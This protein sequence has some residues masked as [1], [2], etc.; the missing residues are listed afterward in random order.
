MAR[1]PASA[2]ALPLLAALPIA[3]AAWAA[4]ADAHEAPKAQEQSQEAIGPLVVGSPAPPLSVDAWGQLPEGVDGYNWES[5][6]G[7]TVVLEFWATW[8]GPCIAAI[9]HMNELAEAFEGEVVFISVTDEPEEKTLA[10]R[11][12]RPMRSVLGFDPDR[13]MLKSYQVRGI[14]ATFVV[15]TGGTIAS[16]THPSRLTKEKLRG[17]IN[18]ERDTPAAETVPIDGANDAAEPASRR[19]TSVASGVDPLDR[20]STVPMGQFILREAAGENMLRTGRGPT[21]VTSLDSSPLE[22]IAYVFEVQ[23]WQVV[24]PEGFKDQGHWD[25][26]VRLPEETFGDQRALVRRLVLDGLGLE[27]T[28]QDRTV[29]GYELRVADGGLRLQEAD[30][31]EPGGFRTSGYTFSS[32]SSDLHSFGHWVQGVLGTPLDTDLDAEARYE[33]DFSMHAAFDPTDA[34]DL[35]MLRQKLEEDL[36]LVLEAKENVVPMVT[37]RPK[38]A[39]E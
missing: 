16:I 37:V 26:I 33:I 13:S 3:Q 36:G 7:R 4:P 23:T 11:E 18:G 38:L 8:C 9:P 15:D 32:A 30:P 19:V 22:L 5:L 25:L 21:N 24:T 2:R 35:A 31:V 10:L 39:S 1:I 14:P 17:Y 27:A 28:V 34:D 6:R 29:S 20:P 12:K